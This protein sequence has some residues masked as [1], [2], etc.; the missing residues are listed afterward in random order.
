MGVVRLWI[1][2]LGLLTLC[3]ACGPRPRIAFPGTSYRIADVD[4]FPLTLPPP[5]TTLAPNKLLTV[6]FPI[7]PG[8][9]RLRNSAACIE[10]ND[11]FSARV[12]AKQRQLI[13]TMPSLMDWR[14]ILLL[15]EQPGNQGIEQKMEALRVAPETLEARGCLSPGSALSLRQVLRD[16]LPVRP[17]QDLYSH[18]FY[19]PAGLGLDLRPGVR[20]K[21]QRAHFSGPPT[22]DGRRSVNDLIGTSTIYYECQEDSQRRASFKR[23]D[24]HFDSDKLTAELRRGSE[25]MR[26]SDRAHPRPIYRLFLLTS[27]PQKGLRRSALIL[28]A[29]SIGRMQA[30]EREISAN[31]AIGCEDL[32]KASDSV[33][34]PFEG[35][36]SVSPEVQVTINGKPAFVDWGSTV[37]SVLRKEGA[38]RAGGVRLRR[39][40]QG[41]LLPVEVDVKAES[42]LGNMALIAG[43]DL[44]WK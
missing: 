10:T 40:F 2:C 8:P 20:I 34:I 28:G 13:L 38:E 32:M 19:R 39:Q 29:S 27:Y 6:Q 26:F 24:V 22:A 36:V 35:D 1:H 37:R 17:G 16:A 5:V 33:C 12:D 3:V 43:D 4:G 21:L 9:A 18:Y 7:S 14:K 42:E 41:Q 23:A 31:L 44:S 15:W 30:M 11:L 25:D